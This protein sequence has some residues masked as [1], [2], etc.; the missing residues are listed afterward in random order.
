MLLVETHVFRVALF[1]VAEERP[2]Q[3]VRI[4]AGK[5]AQPTDDDKGN[6]SQD[7]HHRFERAFGALI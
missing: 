1:G 7:N 5:Q 3:T 6:N 2:L 4:G